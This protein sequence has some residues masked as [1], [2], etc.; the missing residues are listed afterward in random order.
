[1]KIIFLDIDGVLNNELFCRAKRQCDRHK[2]AEEKELPNCVGD[3]DPKSVGFLNE[4]IKDTGAK[5]VISSTWR[6]GGIE[7][8]R[9]ALEA[10]GFEGDIIDVTPSLHHECVVRGNEIYWW[11]QRNHELLG[12]RD[13][14][15][16]V[17]FDDDSD[18]LYWQRNNFIQIDAYAGLT[19]NHCYRAKRLL[20]NET[21]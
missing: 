17:I 14:K 4:L 7:Y 18:M 9:K 20:N 21:N 10:C 12:T 13:F 19:P 5:V 6:H 15:D 16:Y 1:M 2:E 3:I 8:C 11:L